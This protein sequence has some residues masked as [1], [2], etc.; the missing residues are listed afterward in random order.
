ML[1]KKELGAAVQSK[2]KNGLEK[3]EQG[4]AVQTKDKNVLEKKSRKQLSSQ[5]IRMF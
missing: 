4:A 2:D 1:Q 3:K 5:K